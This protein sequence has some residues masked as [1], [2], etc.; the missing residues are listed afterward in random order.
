MQLNG[1]R[2]NNC[3]N[4]SVQIP[5]QRLTCVTGVSGSGK[6][7]LV[8]STLHQEAQRRFT[9]S[10]SR[11][12]GRVLRLQCEARLA[13]AHNLP[14]SIAVK[15]Q[16]SKKD[17]RST[18]G[19]LTEV[20]D[21][22]RLLFCQH[23]VLHCY[24]C[25]QQLSPAA[26]A[27]AAHT[28]ITRAA[29]ANVI[30]AAPLCYHRGDRQLLLTHLREQGLP[31]IIDAQ[32]QRITTPD[33]AASDTYYV[34]T[35]RVR[36]EASNHERLQEAVSTSYR[37]SRG[38]VFVRSDTG[39]SFTL[40]A[41]NECLDCGVSI[42]VP[43]PL[44]FSRYHPLGACPDCQGEQCPSC[45]GER[46]HPRS[47]AY[48]LH[49]ETFGA[50]QRFTVQELER[51]LAVS[52]CDGA[53]KG[54]KSL[55]GAEQGARKGQKSLNGAEQGARKGQKSLNGAEQGAR[56]GQKSLNGAEQGARKRQKSLN[57][58][59]Q[60][61]RKRQK[62]ST[63]EAS[64]NGIYEELQQRLHYLRRLQIDYLTLARD[65]VSMSQGELQRARLALC[66]GTELVDTLYCLD[67]PTSGLHAADSRSMFELLRELQQRGNTVVVVEHDRYFVQQA[68]YLVVIGPA[69]G[70]SGGRVVYAGSP[71]DWSTTPVEI[72]RKRLDTTL[73]DL[74]FITVAGAQTHNLKNI[75]AK[76]PLRRLTCVCGVSGCGKSSLIQHTLYPLLAAQLGQQVPPDSHPRAKRIACNGRIGA[77]VMLNQGLSTKNRRA[78]VATFLGIF[79]QLRE[80]F[81]ALAAARR[82]GFGKA[83]FS[84]NTKQ[85]RCSFCE[86]LGFRENDLAQLGTL[87]EQCP[88][89]RG[90]QFRDEV[91]SVRLQG[92][93][94][95]EVL[96]MT[97]LEARAFLPL[98]EDMTAVLDQGIA[99]GLGYLTLGQAL[100][101]LSGGEMQRMRLVK[102]FLAEQAA[103]VVIFDEPSAGLADQDLAV[104]LRQVELLIAAGHTVIII[105]H[106][107]QL[108][109]CA[110]WIVELGPR[111]AEQGWGD[112]FQWTARGFS[113]L[114]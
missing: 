54:Q 11:Q 84:F 39:D 27:V 55:N 92:K 97:L 112:R 14:P 79:T 110:D 77:V 108:I 68:D 109:D 113:A 70:A 98:R 29:A 99:L 31:R 104:F 13:S 23:A 18:L 46:L 72:K 53:R 10:L 25:E 93:N 32:G 65:A 73:S 102:M 100:S 87:R 103:T 62:A 3:K 88:V 96:A 45:D 86:G 90:Q 67:E 21:F 1:V 80:R 22:L 36:A 94:I 44:H 6:S 111:A 107:L 47:R 42:D 34:V 114:F 74:K 41:N 5:L 26:P 57:G 12:E 7:S 50:V 2:T 89:C 85:G 58:A 91:L 59:E 49:G 9:A 75:T 56:K 37:I 16:F 106:H 81:A 4:I 83:W 15:Q 8:F 43:V 64:G 51:W 63:S 48:R 66:M 24:R 101:T 60:G 17:P 19:S 28:I 78:N 52:M 95:G 30:V 69:A 71:R 82:R 20:S 33:P 76:I 61:A 38:R 35:A 105:D 40:T